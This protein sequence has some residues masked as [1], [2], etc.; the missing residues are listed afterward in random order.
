MLSARSGSGP[1]GC[2]TQHRHWTRP[3]F[4][5]ARRLPHQILCASFLQPM[6]GPCFS[7]DA[8]GARGASPSHGRWV[9]GEVSSPLP[10]QWHAL[11]PSPW[12]PPQ[13]DPGEGLSLWSPTKEFPFVRTALPEMLLTTSL[14]SPRGSWGRGA[15][16]KGFGSKG[17]AVLH[18]GPRTS[19]TLALPCLLVRLGL[20]SPQGS[21]LVLG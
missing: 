20:E 11:G 12:T 9:S 4:D 8:G 6:W 17:A 16:E 14:V 19:G 13:G 18:P 5:T 3:G 7:P 10:H 2:Q 21:V 1:W 15:P